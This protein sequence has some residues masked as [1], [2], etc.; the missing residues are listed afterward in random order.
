MI[1]GHPVQ[2]VL[3]V[4]LAHHLP[5]LKVILGHQVQLSTTG[6]GTLGF[7]GIEPPYLW[8]CE[9]HH[10]D[11]DDDDVVSVGADLDAFVEEDDMVAADLDMH[12]LILSSS[13]NQK[14]VRHFCPP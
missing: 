4:H 2:G 10:R 1:L 14:S 11:D 8:N 5:T 13:D 3:Q 6:T 9:P 12:Q 7:L